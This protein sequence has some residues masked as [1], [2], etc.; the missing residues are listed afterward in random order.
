MRLET[1]TI[2]DF[3]I[4]DPENYWAEME[5]H[6]PDEQ[7]RERAQIE[8]RDHFGTYGLIGGDYRCYRCGFICEG[9]EE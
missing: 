9:D 6:Y 5:S 4:S 8:G 3:I 2:T 7:E 1:R